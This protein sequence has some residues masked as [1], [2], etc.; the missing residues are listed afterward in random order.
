MAIAIAHYALAPLSNQK[1]DAIKILLGCFP[2]NTFTRIFSAIGTYIGTL[3]CLH[4]VSFYVVLIHRAIEQHQIGTQVELINEQF[5]L[6]GSADA[7]AL[8]RESNHFPAP[9]IE[10]FRICPDSDDCLAQLVADDRLAVAVSKLHAMNSRRVRSNQI[11]CFDKRE[12][13]VEYPISV[14][15]AAG[16]PWTGRINEL[17]RWASEGGLVRKWCTD[18][19][20][21]RRKH[22]SN[23][24]GPEVLTIGHVFIGLCLYLVMSIISVGAFAVEHIIHRRLQSSNAGRFWR[25]ADKL[26]DGKR[27]YLLPDWLVREPKQRLVTFRRPIQKVRFGRF[28]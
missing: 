17:T 26:I 18:S 21:N 14:L 27:H 8:I 23:R 6:A 9:M 3:T 28:H 22:Y 25:W 19:A 24:N 5:Q 13:I 1:F 16:N 4:V 11:H 15:I 10:Q 20:T 12:Q 7:L 2:K